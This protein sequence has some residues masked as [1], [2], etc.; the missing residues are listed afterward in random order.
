MRRHQHR[1]SKGDG[2]DDKTI[3]KQQDYGKHDG[4]LQN[5]QEN[6]NKNWQKGTEKNVEKF[7]TEQEE[8]KQR[9][10]ERRRTPFPLITRS[11]C[12]FH[13]FHTI[14]QVC[15]SSPTGVE[16]EQSSRERSPENSSRARQS[17]YKIETISKSREK[18]RKLMKLSKLNNAAATKKVK[19]LSGGGQ[20][21][22][23]R[24][25]QKKREGKCVLGPTS[26]LMCFAFALATIDTLC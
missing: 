19:Y 26:P 2:E 10:D 15:L 17:V 16:I 23:C 13:Y 11:I 14:E 5:L 6:V 3:D 12:H 24:G 8:D 7:E 4:N 25:K 1:R 9:N 20:R 21:Y 18:N 22:I